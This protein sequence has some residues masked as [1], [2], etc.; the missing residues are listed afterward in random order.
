VE[1][2]GPPDHDGTPVVTLREAISKRVL[3][4]ARRSES[5]AEA[6]VQGLRDGEARERARLVPL[7]EQYAAERAAVERSNYLGLWHAIYCAGDCRR[8]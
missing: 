8:N 3:R 4:N 6:Y 2:G 7:A 5:L 1:R